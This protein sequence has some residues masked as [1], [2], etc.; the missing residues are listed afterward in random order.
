MLSALIMAGG[1]GTRFWPLSTENKPKQFL[2]LLGEDTMLQKTVKRILPIIDIK[3]IFI[4]TAERYV[5]LVKEQLP[6]LPEK[7]IIVE[8]EGRNTAPCIALSSLVIK[9]YYHN[10]SILVLPSDHLIGKEE[11]F[12]RLVVES[13]R[14]LDSIKDGII[15]FGMKATRPETGYGY[16]KSENKGGEGN[17]LRKVEKFVE[18]PNKEL[19][20]KYLQEGSYLW[21]SGMFLWKTDTIVNNIKEHLPNTYEALRPVGT[22]EEKDLKKVIS[23]NYQKTEAISIDYGVLEKAKNIYVVPTEVAWDDIGSWEAME[24]Y[25]KKD[26]SGNIHIGEINSVS[27]S[28]NLIV[29]SNQKVIIDNLSDIYVVEN[30]GQIVIGR[31]DRVSNLKN[32]KNII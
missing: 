31:K 12:R 30:E 23:D 3:N 11:E 17:F 7:N 14:K 18:K 19:A 25:C 4:C 2:K 32:L 13:K 29:A 16:I 24:R 21:N 5:N 26:N 6:N 8:P 27:S 10:P 15:T 9:R 20:E 22:C 1:Q 28:N